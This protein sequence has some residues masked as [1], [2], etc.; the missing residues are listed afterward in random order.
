MTAITADNPLP[1][2]Y[3]YRDKNGR[4]VAAFVNRKADGGLVCRVGDRMEDPY[5]VWTYLADNKITREEAKFWFENGR[6]KDEPEK[7]VDLRNLPRDPFEALKVQIEAKTE[8]YERYLKEYPEVKTE[9]VC[10]LFRNLQ[11]EFQGF[12]REA[13]KMF[14]TE[15]EPW[16][17]GGRKVDKKFR[18]RDTL[19]TMIANLGHRYGLYMAEEERRRKAEAVA[20]FEAEKARIEAERAKQKED[21]PIAYH[22]SPDPELP[23]G[24]EPVK[25]QAGG[26]Y[27]R[28]AGLKDDW[29]A[30]VEDY[31]KAA[32][33][34]LKYPELRAVIDKLSQHAVK[35]AKGQI[36]I[37]GVKVSLRR[38]PA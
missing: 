6:W 33:Y 28:K 3:K 12:K 17:E 2:W 32:K 5:R 1:G 24:P 11:T 20:K 14:E 23:L 29:R 34:F 26:L 25:V 13:N 18:F 30:E 27:D 15:K 38:I 35:D 10:N 9:E 7:V 19:T 31:A 16:L 36:K 21:D 37:P 22:T 8:Q 4:W